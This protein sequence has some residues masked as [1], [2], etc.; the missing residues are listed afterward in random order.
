[1]IGYKLFSLKRDGSI[2]PLFINRK[3]RLQIGEWHEAEDHP[4]PGYA[5]R[6][7][8]HIL[9]SKNAPHLSKKGRVWAKVEFEDAESYHRPEA[10]GGLWFLAKRMR[11]L[12]VDKVDFV[13]GQ[14]NGNG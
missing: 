8:W 10:Q 6:P 3:L 12:E 1:M 14:A 13:N 11:V 4:T 2:G 5:H 9:G 7:G